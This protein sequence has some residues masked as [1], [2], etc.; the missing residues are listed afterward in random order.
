MNESPIRRFEAAIL[1]TYGA[2]PTARGASPV[3]EKLESGTVW[4]GTVLI[5]DLEGHPTAKQCYAWEMNGECRCA[6]RS[7]PVETAGDA[8]RASLL[9]NRE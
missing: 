1:K 6:L 7:P 3:H 2:K 5:F 4:E 9:P 8:V